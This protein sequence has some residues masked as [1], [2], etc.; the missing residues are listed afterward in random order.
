[1]TYSAGSV[2]LTKGDLKLLDSKTYKILS[3]NILFHPPVNAARMYLKR[4]EQGRGL[5]SVKYCVLSE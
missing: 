5:I 2:D 4:F 3:C 1:M